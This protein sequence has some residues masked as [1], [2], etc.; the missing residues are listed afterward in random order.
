MDLK[1]VSHQESLYGDIHTEAAKV[2]GAIGII[3]GSISRENDF[4]CK[5]WKKF[6]SQWE[7]EELR[8]Q[9]LTI[10]KELRQ[11]NGLFYSLDSMRNITSVYY[12]DQYIALH[13]TEY[14]FRIDSDRYLFYIRFNPAKGY[15]YI[16]AYWRDEIEIH[17]KSAEKGVT[18][19][20]INNHP[21]FTVSNGDQILII[22]DEHMKQ[23]RT[24]R[25]V[26]D[27]RIQVGDYVYTPH[28][29]ADDM[30]DIEAKF[31]PF[32]RSLPDIA[33]YYDQ[34]TLKVA[35]A[36][37]GEEGLSYLKDQ[38]TPTQG[39]ALVES[40]NKTN[41]VT[42]EQLDAMWIGATVSWMDP[43]ANIDTEG[44]GSCL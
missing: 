30:D 41:N 25:Y 3:I 2:T 42:K 17:M 18:F 36:K 44:K 6:N 10:I 4:R 23:P 16:T 22:Y 27:H 13:N 43:A 7:A 28:E 5:S 33:Y 31:V 14:V 20:D 39:T 37:K 24:V 38:Y 12:D 40:Y 29:F 32:R 11:K 1:T 15:F 34:N 9:T 19:V 35:I 26:D 21:I 8:N